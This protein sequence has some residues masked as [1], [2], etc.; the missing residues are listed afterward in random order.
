MISYSY[1]N[2]KKREKNVAGGNVTYSVNLIGCTKIR[3]DT[4]IMEK[5]ERGKMWLARM[6]LIP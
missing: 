2:P 5:R 6:S 1:L 3:S 4:L